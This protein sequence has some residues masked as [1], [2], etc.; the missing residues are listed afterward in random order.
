MRSPPWLSKSTQQKCKNVQEFSY[1]V[2]AEAHSSVLFK[3]LKTVQCIH[4]L[5]HQC[6]GCIF[7]GAFLLLKLIDNVRR[8]LS[9]L[10]IVY[11][12]LMYICPSWRTRPVVKV[13][14]DLV[15]ELRWSGDILQVFGQKSA[16]R[17]S[18]TV[19]DAQFRTP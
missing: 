2:S 10:L 4:L 18:D 13:L 3:R 8:L 12:S 14:L 16:F 9:S 15:L 17:P 11:R 19:V 5:G 6:S 1:R 7:T